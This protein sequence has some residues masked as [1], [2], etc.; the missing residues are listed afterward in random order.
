M[1]C[2]IFEPEMDVII[3]SIADGHVQ[4]PCKVV[5][6]NDMIIGF[7][8]LY[9]TSSG[10]SSK[11]LLTSNM[12]YVLQ[13]HRSFAILKELYNEIKEAAKLQGVPYV[14]NYACTDKFDVRVRL[15]ESQNLKMIGINVMYEVDNG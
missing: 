11:R 14:D 8:S 2:S 12:V 5:V 13:E 7:A 1:D 9:F 4:V 3:K 10:W 15:S 6:K